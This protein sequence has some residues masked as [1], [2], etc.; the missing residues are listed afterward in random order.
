MTPRPGVPVSPQPGRGGPAQYLP[1]DHLSKSSIQLYLQCPEKWRRRYIERDREPIGVPMLLGGAVGAAEI[2]NYQQKISSGVDLSL[3]DVLDLYAGEVDERVDTED[4]DWQ[5]EKPGAVKDQGAK[6]AAVYHTTIAPSVMPV[7]AERRVAFKLDG[8]EWDFQGYID[9]ET[10]AGAVADLKVKAKS[11]TPV[12]LLSNLDATAYLAARRAEGNPAPTFEFHV[13]KK[14]K[15]PSAEI[16]T[17]TRTDRQLDRFLQRLAQI[18]REIEWR[19]E[20][21]EWAGAPPGAWWCAEKTCGFWKSC[22][23]GGA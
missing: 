21:G 8:A 18:S 11:F 4:V 10:E 9:F 7:S 15:E 13:V 14:T 5:A 1:V 6:L 17:A 12:E 16:V 22:R 19:Y 2:A 23:Y 3:G 20:T